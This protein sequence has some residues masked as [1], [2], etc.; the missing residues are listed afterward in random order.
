[1]EVYLV[2]RDGWN[3]WSECDSINEETCD[4][5][6]KF[7]TPEGRLLYDK[8]EGLDRKRD[9]DC[10]KGG[11]LFIYTMTIEVH[12]RGHD[13][14]L[15]MVDKLLDYLGGRWTIAWIMPF[16]TT[17]SMKTVSKKNGDID[18][19]SDNEYEEE[20][21]RSQVLR[22]D[23]R[24]EIPV[25]TFVTTAGA[26]SQASA[27][28]LCN[29]PMIAEIKVIGKGVRSYYKLGTDGL[30]AVDRRAAGVQQSY[31]RKAAAMDEAMGIQGEGPCMRRLREFPEVLDLCFGAW[32]EGSAGVHKM[33]ACLAACRVLTMRLQ[34]KSPSPHQLGLETSIIRRRL[35]AAVV[36]ANNELLLARIGQV[37]EGSALAGKRRVLQRGEEHRMMLQR[38]ADWLVHTTGRELV[39]RGRFWRR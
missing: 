10:N 38:E 26:G 4:I 18:D 33:V 11:F 1:M 13:L 28:V 36:R 9:K 23:L 34:G 8:I 37:G 25:L 14:S 32:G 3:F 19:E 7:T 12:E 16:A 20:E 2:G 6:L 17:V 15:D 5:A 24:L 27:P 29:G 31:E 35:R 30:R 39:R 22:P 21:R